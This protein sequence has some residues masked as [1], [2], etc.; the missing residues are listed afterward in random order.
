MATVSADLTLQPLGGEPRT[1]A[2]QVNLFQLVVVAIDPYTNQ[3]AWL[4]E[5]AGR[6]LTEF[7]GADCR[8]AFLV[9]APEEDAR[10]FL[11]PWVDRVMVFC[12]PD[13]TAVAGLGIEQIPALVH[14]GH[15]LT[16][17]G[18]AEGWDAETWRPVLDNLAAMMSWSRPALPRPGDPGAFA[19]TP[20]AG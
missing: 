4:L 18:S 13:R 15:D 17:V 3:S 1:A 19:G 20:A 6:L 11:G 14:V 12:D 8:V 16:V 9:T 5:T 10:A 2:E 7:S